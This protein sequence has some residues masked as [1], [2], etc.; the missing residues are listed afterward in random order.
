MRVSCLFLV[1]GKLGT[2]TLVVDP[3]PA[4]QH[5]VVLAVAPPMP[6]TMPEQK[7][8]AKGKAPVC[9]MTRPHTHKVMQV[10]SPSPGVAEAPRPNP[11]V[12]GPSAALR[13]P[14]F[15]ESILLGSGKIRPD[16]SIPPGE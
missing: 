7:V 4:T 12:A 6:A 8:T 11:P 15:K 16:V 2:E 3:V 13:P 1:P 10:P 9:W 5:R 14:L